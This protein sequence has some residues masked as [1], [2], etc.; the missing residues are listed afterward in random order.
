MA[1]PSRST[2]ATPSWRSSACRSSARTTRSAPCAPRTRCRPARPCQRELAVAGGWRSRIAPAS[3]P[4]GRRRR[5]GDR[6]APGHRRH[7]QYRRPARAGRRPGRDTHRSAHL[8]SRSR[9]RRGRGGRGA[10][11]QGQGRARHGISAHTVV[12]HRPTG[13]GSRRRLSAGST[14]SCAAVEELARRD[15]A[16]GRCDPRWRRRCRQIATHR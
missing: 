10:R 11:P 13:A 16:P 5:S 9:R 8:R 15:N 2:S 6:S 4:G 1:A 3:T 14:S 7:G 12:G